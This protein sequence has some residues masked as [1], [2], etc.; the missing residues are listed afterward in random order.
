VSAKHPL[1]GKWT[2]SRSPDLASLG[3]D[4]VARLTPDAVVTYTAEGQLSPVLGGHTLFEENFSWQMCRDEST[5]GQGDFK[6][7]RELGS[8]RTIHVRWDV[9]PGLYWLFCRIVSTGVGTLEPLYLALSQRVMDADQVRNLLDLGIR[10]AVQSGLPHPDR[11]D[12]LLARH[13][14]NIELIVKNGPPMTAEQRKKTDEYLTKQGELRAKT[15]VLL[16]ETFARRREPIAALHIEHATGTKRQLN[17]FVAAMLRGDEKVGWRLVDWTNPAHRNGYDWWYG[18]GKTDKEAIDAAIKSWDSQNRFPPGTIR[19]RVPRTVLNEPISTYY[20]FETDGASTWDSIIGALGIIALTTGVI[21]MGVATLGLGVPAATAASIAAYATL[22]SGVAGAGAEII[23]IAQRRAEG[24]SNLKDDMLSALGIV[25]AVFSAPAQVWKRGMTVVLGAERGVKAGEYIFLGATGARM[26][27]DT[28]QGVFVAASKIDELETIMKDPLLL[29]EERERKLMLTLATLGG[30]SLLTAVSVKSGTHEIEAVMQE[31]RIAR[32]KAKAASAPPDISTTTTVVDTTK[33]PVTES[34]TTVTETRTIGNSMRPRVRG[35]DAF[36]TLVSTRAVG[37]SQGE[38]VG[39]LGLSKDNM[40]IMVRAGSEARL[41]IMEN[42]KWKDLIVAK[43]DK[44]KFKSNKNAG[45]D[46]YGFV[47]DGDADGH[48]KDIIAKH[49]DAHP[50]DPWEFSRNFEDIREHV[51]REEGLE[52]E[53]PPHYRIKQKGKDGKYFV[54]DVD[55]HGAYR[56]NNGNPFNTNKAK[57]RKRINDAIAPHGPDVVLHG[58]QAEW[59]ARMSERGA[60]VNYGPQPPVIAY[61]D[62]VAV[63]LETWAD[64]LG[65]ATDYNIELLEQFPGFDFNKW[66]DHIAS[67]YNEAQHADTQHFLERAA[68]EREA[69]IKRFGALPPRAGARVGGT[70]TGG[71]T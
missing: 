13:I 34:H 54:A 68:K 53:N 21:A 65:F 12:E 24:T 4:D 42:P 43:N 10:K 41:Q 69:Y 3:P 38:H 39:L 70:S 19:F 33:M 9:R 63:R 35:T 30:Q 20:E 61:V 47:C 56:R 60:G 26:T 28:V 66:T 36:P 31:R 15:K 40:I 16:D 6:R 48:V 71:G 7:V 50:H 58:G 49:N 44:V 1:E 2:I 29:P 64:M 32:A 62:G 5:S 45:S 27:A 37:L 11:A 14:E 52:I 51:L 18:E 23:S 67:Y 25:S 46:A 17:M 22:T 8:N 55:L 59:A 57:F